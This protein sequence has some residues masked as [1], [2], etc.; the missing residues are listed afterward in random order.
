M[1]T[2]ELTDGIL[3]AV[4]FKSG[5][6]TFLRFFEY[7]EFSDFME[8][9]GLSHIGFDDNMFWE[10]VFTQSD[11]DMGKESY[12]GALTE[13]RKKLLGMKNLPVITL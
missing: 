7:G 11:V 1:A 8:S 6:R 12:R 10:N 13:K 2:S 4:A 3:Y 5:Q 9:K